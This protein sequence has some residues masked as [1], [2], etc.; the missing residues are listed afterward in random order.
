M[1]VF[2]GIS[3]TKQPKMPLKL[4]LS[5]LAAGLV[6]PVFAA[7]PSNLPVVWSTNTPVSTKT[8]RL[9]QAARPGTYSLLVSASPAGFGENDRL[10][11]E[12]VQSG[13]TLVSKTLH[14]GDAD[15]YA[16][17]RVETAGFHLRASVERDDKNGNLSLG[18]RS[19]HRNEHRTRRRFVPS[20]A[21]RPH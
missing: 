5:V 11:V 9:A 3:I 16:P 6:L 12:I 14:A 4:S 15:L 13:Q 20:R 8:I 18:F 10:S 2:G 1:S 21:G 19:E 17:F 7:S